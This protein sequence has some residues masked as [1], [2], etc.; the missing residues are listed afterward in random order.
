MK[1]QG[2]RLVRK[3]SPSR[4][5]GIKSTNEPKCFKDSKD[6]KDS[7]DFKE[8]K[9]SK[10]VKDLKEPKDR[11]YSKDSKD[12][13]DIKNLKDTKDT[14]GRQREREEEPMGP[15]TTADLTIPSFHYFSERIEAKG[16]SRT[17]LWPRRKIVPF[18]L[19][20]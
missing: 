17:E 11:K 3:S 20:P 19:T 2:E 7:K 18:H 13:K 5:K 4:A 15:L 12:L 9:D 16:I 14:K 8:R 6:S 10:D 1:K